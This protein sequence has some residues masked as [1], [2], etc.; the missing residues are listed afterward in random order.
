MRWHPYRFDCVL[1]IALQLDLFIHCNIRLLL[2]FVFLSGKNVY[3]W[4]RMK[5]VVGCGKLR[6]VSYWKIRADSTV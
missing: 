5:I 3:L 2:S 1:Q 4:E 6:S